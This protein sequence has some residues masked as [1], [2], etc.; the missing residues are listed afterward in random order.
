MRT[1]REWNGFWLGRCNWA[2][3]QACLGT[4]R[5]LILLSGPRG[6]GK[7][8]LL[9]TLAAH[10]R[11]ERQCRYLRCADLLED[12]IQSIQSGEGE[13]FAK[14]YR[15]C[16]LLVDDGSVLSGKK[17][18]Q[19]ELSRLAEEIAA[20]G[21]RMILVADSL[22]GAKRFRWVALRAPDRALRRRYLEDFCQ[23]EGL[24]LPAGVKRRCLRR[25]RRD[26]RQL[27]GLLLTE[28]A[29]RSLE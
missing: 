11:A 24:M 3:W 23:K 1:E 15:H 4:E 25:C 2:G 19:A 9:R 26:L 27:R 5:G 10:P 12:L 28:E 13:F 8:H 20:E 17:T 6:S 7:T 21:G 18:V 16:D 14:T 29:R 22:A